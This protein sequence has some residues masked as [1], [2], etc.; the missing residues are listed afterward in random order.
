MD[1]Y[2]HKKPKDRIV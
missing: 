1:D 2:I